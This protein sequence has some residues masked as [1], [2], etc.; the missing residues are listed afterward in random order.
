[1]TKAAKVAV[2]VAGVVLA[3]ACGG[4]ASAEPPKPRGWRHISVPDESGHSLWT[5]CD[6]GNRIYVTEHWDKA[7]VAVAAGDPSCTVAPK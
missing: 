3:T 6:G 7:A 1:M 5:F 4:S 2:V